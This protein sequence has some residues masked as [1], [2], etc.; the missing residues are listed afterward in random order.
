MTAHIIMES[1][2]IMETKDRFKGIFQGVVDIVALTDNKHNI[3]MVNRAFEKLFKKSAHKC[4]GQKCHV[5]IRKK[6]TVC[7]DCPVEKKIGNNIY[8]KLLIPVGS[9]NVSI[10]RHPIYND[11]GA[12]QGT[13]VIGRIVTGELKMQQELQHQGRLKIMGELASSIVHEIKNPLAG[14]GLM[15]LSIM[16][17]LK[18]KDSIYFDLESISHEV[19]RLEHMLEG[20]TNFAKPSLFKLKKTYIHHFIDITIKLL[21][22]K[23]SAGKIKVNKIYDSKV[24]IL[25]DPSKMQQVFFNILLNSITAMPNG[26]EININTS[27]FREKIAEDIK[28]EWVRITVQDTGVGINEEDLPYIYDP[29]FS[30]SSKGTGLGLSNVYRI[31]ELHNGSINIQS[32]EG[33]GTTVKM[34]IPIM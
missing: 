18:Q 28:N 7:I 32:Q 14:I 17:R 29:F 3:L 33:V 31:I 24:P 26:G 12:L 21:N 13:F 11:Q 20:L 9:D 5:I 10:T 4:I 6:K 22:K 30:K 25:I 23:L 16:E 8:D 34:Y 19:Q 15:T 1:K 27:I 2:D